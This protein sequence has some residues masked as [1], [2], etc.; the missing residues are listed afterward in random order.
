MTPNM[1]SYKYRSVERIKNNVELIIS[2]KS[3][4]DVVFFDDAFLLHPQLQE[5][6]EMLS[7]FE[8]RYHLPNGIHAKKVSPLVAKLLKKANF[9]TIRLGYE[10]S[11]SSLQ[12]KTGGKVSN[13]DLVKAVANLKDAGFS[14][15]DIGAY[16]IGNLPRQN[17]DD[18]YNAINFCFDL[19]IL[20]IVNEYTPIP[21]TND[22]YD[23][24]EQEVFSSD[25]DPF[26]LNNKYLPFWWHNGIDNEQMQEIKDYL[27]I[28]RSKF[29]KRKAGEL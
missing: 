15:T 29:V 26:L 2:K 8:T 1:W 19:E 18:I 14:S 7:T 16:I 28:E 22:Y 3:I 11:D 5:L 20:P 13:A 12:K 6:L 10:T 21:G 23:L 25:I 27:H 4:K 9:K 24:L 17:K